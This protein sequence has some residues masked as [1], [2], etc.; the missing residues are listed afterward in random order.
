MQVFDVKDHDGSQIALFLLDCYA[1]DN[2]QGG[3]WMNDYVEQSD[4]LAQVPIIGNHANFPLPAA[5]GGGPTLLSLDDV[6]TM[7]HEF[8]HALHGLFSKVANGCSWR[9]RGGLLQGV[10]LL[11]LLLHLLLLQNLLLRAA[12]DGDGNCT[13][14]LFRSPCIELLGL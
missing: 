2:K 11:L 14:V 10:L 6:T 3:A 13:R 9:V 12:S 4:L 1:R 8:G 7:F 5:E